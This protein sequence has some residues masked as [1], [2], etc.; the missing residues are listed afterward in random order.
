MPRAKKSPSRTEMGFFG[1]EK[2]ALGDEQGPIRT[3]KSLLETKRVLL[4]H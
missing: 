1:A 3:E 2:W 4:D